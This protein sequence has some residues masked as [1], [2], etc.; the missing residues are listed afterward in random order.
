MRGNSIGLLIAKA[1]IKAHGRTLS[2]VSQHG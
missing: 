1:V 2:L